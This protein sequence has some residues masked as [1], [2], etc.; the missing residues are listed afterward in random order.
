MLPDAFSLAGR[1]AWVTGAGSPD[2]I[3]FAT[4]SL[5][6]AL[7]ADVAL[8]ATSSRVDDRVAELSEARHPRRRRR[9]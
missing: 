6:G 1:V 3:G 9:R 4:A 8:G 7:G 5:L 2:G